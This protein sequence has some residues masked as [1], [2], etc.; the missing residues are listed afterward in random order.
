VSVVA[1]EVWRPVPGYE[2]AYDISDR[3]DVKSL[4]RV[5]V[6]SA[7]RVRSPY[8]RRVRERI[9]QPGQKVGCLYVTLSVEGVRR[10][11]YVHK[12]VA[13]VFGDGPPRRRRARGISSFSSRARRSG[14]GSAGELGD[15]PGNRPW[16]F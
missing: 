5:I 1:E 2:G 9:L 15:V 13:K 8:E 12:L 11:F 3:G 14:A 6:V 7:G 10:G 4:D 16:G